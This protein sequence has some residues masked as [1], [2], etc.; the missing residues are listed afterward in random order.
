MS[1]GDGVKASEVFRALLDS[2]SKSQETTKS[3]AEALNKL[4]MAVEKSTELHR[5][6]DTKREVWF[7]RIIAFQA[8]VIAAL[9][10]VQVANLAGLLGAG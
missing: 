4:T 5:D 6:K 2:I 8:A 3:V 9:A 1:N 10:G 7:W